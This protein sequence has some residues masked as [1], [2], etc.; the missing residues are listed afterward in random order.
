MISKKKKR[1]IIVNN[2]EYWWQVHYD[3][4]CARPYIFISSDRNKLLLKSSYDRETIISGSTIE[5]LIK[6]NNL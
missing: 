5:K 6:D 4:D 3:K 2:N 1:K